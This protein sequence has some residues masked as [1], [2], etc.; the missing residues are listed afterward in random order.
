MNEGVV[1]EIDIATGRV[2]FEWHSGDHVDP[3]ESYEPL[4]KDEGPWDYFHVNSID[5][6]GQGSLLVSARHT[7]AVY[8]IRKSPTEHQVGVE[9]LRITPADRAFL[10]S[11]V[12]RKTGQGNAAAPFN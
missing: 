9:F 7:H 8:E 2:L 4:P 12:G 5:P 3:S 10:E 6:D 1:Q 11:F